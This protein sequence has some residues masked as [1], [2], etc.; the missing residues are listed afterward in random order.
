MLLSYIKFYNRETVKS[1]FLSQSIDYTSKAK[2]LRKS[3]YDLTRIY[4]MLLQI[5][6]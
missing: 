6:E 5:I 2:I 3:D 4:M 1:E